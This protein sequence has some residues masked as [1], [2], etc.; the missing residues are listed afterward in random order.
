M[1]ASCIVRDAQ[2]PCAARVGRARPGH[3]P[4]PDRPPRPAQPGQGPH[5]EYGSRL[6][7]GHRQGL[8][9]RVRPAGGQGR[10]ADGVPRRQA[11]AA[12]RRAGA[13]QPSH[14][15]EPRSACA[16]RARTTRMLTFADFLDLV[17]GRVPMLV[18][19]KTNSATPLDP[20]L[21]RIAR[22][23]RA[24]KGPIALMSFDLDVVAALA[25]LAPT[26]PRGPVMGSHQLP[27]R[28]WATPGAA[29]RA[30]IARLLD[31]LPAG[32]ALPR[33]RRA[34]AAGDAGVD[35]APRARPA[36]V[37]LDHPL[38]S[39]ARHGRPLRRRADLRDLRAVTAPA[40]RHSRRAK[41]RILLG[42]GSEPIYSHPQP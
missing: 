1:T 40:R 19:V 18:E 16:T 30:T 35:D 31:R 11:R 3:V 34:H 27:A 7:R 29:G 17:G 24:Y 36:A 42:E 32:S 33:R 9:H 23:A 15:R 21:D 25:K 6:R 12:H 2:A 8:R 41:S 22:Q 13:N 20:F 10:H 14:A 28:L 39:R 38:P 4:A 37:Q 26:I 5:R